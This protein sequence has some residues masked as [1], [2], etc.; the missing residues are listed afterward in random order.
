MTEEEREEHNRKQ[1]EWWANMP[2]EKKEKYKRKHRERWANKTQEEREE[3]N[4]KHKERW[5]NM[6]KE[7]REEHNRKQKERWANMPKEEREEYYKKK[8]ERWANRPK[9]KRE[10]H[11]RKQRERWANMPKEKREEHNRKQKERW[12][13]M[14]KEKREECYKKKRERQSKNIIKSPTVRSMIKDFKS[15]FVKRDFSYCGE[16]KELI[17]DNVIKELKNMTTQPITTLTMPHDG[18]ELV[19]LEDE[20]LL[21]VKGSVGVEYDRIQ[22]I[23]LIKGLKNFF[24]YYRMERGCIKDY[25]DA[26][27]KDFDFAHIDLNGIVG[28]IRL[29]DNIKKLLASG[30]TTQLTFA[31][32][33]R[34]WGSTDWGLVERIMSQ[35]DVLMDE[36]YTGK[37]GFKMQSILLRKAS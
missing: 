18:R 3:H 26:T 17:T 5:A 13:N 22:F 36:A 30:T 15:I 16:G 34:F 27:N 14:P 8:R 31:H 10:E 11:N 25:I 7:K 6:P 23:K 1:R 37:K 24:P 20:G 32:K 12:A 21:K 29:L 19:C 35:G 9:E 28:D 4:R 33:N 2:E